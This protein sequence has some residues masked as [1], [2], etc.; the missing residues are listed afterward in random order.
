MFPKFVR[1]RT[2]FKEPKSKLFYMLVEIY[3]FTIYLYPQWPG[4]SG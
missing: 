3:F 1:Y 4:D 2:F